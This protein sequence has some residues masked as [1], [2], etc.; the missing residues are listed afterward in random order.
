AIQ[1]VNDALIT[2]QRDSEKLGEHKKQLK[3]ETEDFGYTQQ[4][5]D[6]GIISK[7]D[8]V[9]MKENLLTVNQLVSSTT[10]DC[11]VDYISLYK[12]TGSKI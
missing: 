10:A 2:V 8:L 3:L 9:Q 11:Y 12:A 5:Y 4:R 6:A 1:E 7:L